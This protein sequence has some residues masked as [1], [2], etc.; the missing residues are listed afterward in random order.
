MLQTFR[1]NT[2]SLVVKV[3]I[4]L[5][6]ITFALFGVESLVGLASQPDAP[7]SINGS[8]ISENQLQNA[9]ERQRRQMLTQMGQNADPS[10]LDEGVIRQ[11][12][13]NDMVQRELMRQSTVDNNMAIAEQL[14]DQTI[15]STPEFQT[16]GK[17]DRN[18][19]EMVLRNVGM[20]PLTFRDYL[21]NEMLGGQDRTGFVASSFVL[22]NEINQ[23]T[24]L[25][26]QTRDIYLAE[27]PLGDP[28][29]VDVT[30]KEI[31]D[32]YN[33]HQA[34]YQT[35]EMLSVNYVELNKLD[36]A[37]TIEVD[38]AAVNTKYENL[39]ADFTADEARDA[40]H[41]LIAIDDDTDEAAAEQLINELSE[42]I[43][44]G[45]D[46]ASLAGEFSDDPGSAADGGS[47]GVVEKG[48]MVPE[49]EEALFALEEGQVSSPVQTDFGYH[50][51]KLNNIEVQAPPSLA[52]SRAQIE[53]ELKME[54]AEGL[55][56][57]RSEELDD[58]RFSSSD[59]EEVSEILELPIQTTEFFDR[60]GGENPLTQ[61]PKLLVS[62]F[63]DEVLKDGE[64]SGLIELDSNRV[65][66]INVNE[67]RPVRAEELSEVKDQVR[68]KIAM[69]KLL[70]QRK[71]E[72]QELAQSVG[73]ASALTGTDPW[74]IV[75]AVSRSD[76]RVSPEVLNKLF[77]L[78]TPEEG[79]VTTAVVETDNDKIAV[80]AMTAVKQNEQ[81]LADEQLQ[82]LASFLAAQKGQQD[83]QS[84]I[85]QL[86]SEAEIELN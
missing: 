40:A 86:R 30:E 14:L 80:I 1:D 22:P 29:S 66:V 53:N 6:I 67:Y 71:A 10:L 36:L 2:Q 57:K 13:I 77:R 37:K 60:E 48:V 65:I 7:V 54:Q 59:L 33:L 64:N 62:A 76:S 58:L 26:R 16:D 8:D 3:I 11:A 35:D 39:V 24:S 79:G 34:E 72:G 52:E 12:V 20:T 27:L 21:R 70:E 18:R 63:S 55:F 41:I 50:L 19:F 78:A 83:Y 51:I 38:E 74:Q 43:A 82:S 42:K 47:L 23:L 5:I 45:G 44:N 85:A 69:Q 46:F 25:D 4:G 61:N 68:Q 32:T 31:S 73:D 56:I 28:A 49:F 84:R 17:F 75:S 9:V 81:E 15:V